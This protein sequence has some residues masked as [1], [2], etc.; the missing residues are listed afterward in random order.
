MRKSEP[1]SE[2][3]GPA[4]HRVVK[5]TCETNLE[6]NGEDWCMCPC[7]FGAEGRSYGEGRRREGR[8]RGLHRTRQRLQTHTTGGAVLAGQEDVAFSA[9]VQPRLR[10]SEPWSEDCG[11]ELQKS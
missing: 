1:W 8:R 10:I 3:C 11:R 2:D 7:G 4:L 9:H 6:L 5:Q